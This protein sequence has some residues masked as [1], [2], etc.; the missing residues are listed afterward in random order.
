[1][2]YKPRDTT[3]Q[4]KRPKQNTIICFS[5]GYQGYKSKDPNYPAKGR[6]CRKCSGLG[7]FEAR[8]KS[9]ISVDPKVQ[10]G[11]KWK[12]TGKNVRQISQLQGGGDQ[13]DYAFSISNVTRGDD[14]ITLDVTVGGVW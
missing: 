7:H 12:Q 1:M 9:K 2:N 8:C 11:Q 14:D 5:C 3:P 4:V 6:K 13:D 10:K